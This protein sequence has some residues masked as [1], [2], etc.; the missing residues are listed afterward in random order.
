MGGHHINNNKNGNTIT[1]IIIIIIIVTLIKT[2]QTKVPLQLPF[3]HCCQLKSSLDP[4]TRKKPRIVPKMTTLP[5][6]TSAHAPQAI[7]S[8]LAKTIGRPKAEMTMPVV[9]KMASSLQALLA[10]SV[11]ST[12]L[13]EM[14]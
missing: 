7:T 12:T 3:Y 1:V 9:R 2:V 4:K 11:S 6:S 8:A 10:E 5:V 14:Q 13:R